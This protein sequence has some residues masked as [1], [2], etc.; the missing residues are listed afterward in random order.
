LLKNVTQK[1]FG[2]SLAGW[3]FACW[4]ANCIA[5]AELIVR[6]YFKSQEM[7]QS[8]QP[9][10]S[11]KKVTVFNS[12]KLYYIELQTLLLLSSWFSK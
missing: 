1:D 2:T 6:Y 11:N 10:P 5:Y 8:L 3:I 9:F 7:I 12:D 4:G